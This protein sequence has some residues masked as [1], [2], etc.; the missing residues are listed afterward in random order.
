M[1]LLLAAILLVSPVT[2]PV[3]AQVLPKIQLE[4]YSLANGLRVVL[5]PDRSTQVVT[6][7]VWYDVGSRNEVRGR[8]GF[9]HLFEHMMFQGSANVKKAEYFALIERAGGE[10]NASTAE[11]RTNYYAML[12]SNRLNLGLWLEAD[13]MRALAITAENLDN[14]REAVKEE[15]RLR[16][17]NQ[18]YAGVIYEG[19]YALEDSTRCFSYSHS[20][21]GSM[22]DLNAAKVDD[23][24]SFFDL[25]YAPNNATLVVAGDFEPTETRR[26]VESYFGGIPRG[27]PTPTVTCT[28]SFDRGEIRRPW[29]DSKATLPAAI[30]AY[31]IPSFDD[32]D[33]PALALLATMLGQG[34]SSRLNKTVV[35]TQRLA[36][37]VFA[38]ANLAG[39][40]RG[41]GSLLVAGFANQGIAVNAVESAMADEIARIGREGVSRAE[42]DK[43]KNGYV[44][45]R[46]QQQ[47]ISY[48]LAETIQ[49]AA[50]FLGDPAKVNTEP[51]R[52]LA[53]TV[54]D[55]RR[56]AAK[57]LKPANSAVFLVTPAAA[58]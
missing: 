51:A 34:E 31:R 7:D 28:P 53:V 44:A 23:V 32:P 11:D 52:F 22:A 37:G 18:P 50:M 10:T 16:V 8:T 4:T 21:I 25:Y 26:L 35:R 19:V 43:A 30:L 49:E 9:A 45:N 47:Q 2:S 36:Q 33:Y 27:Q 24:K 20:V 6:V 5:A 29:P 40:R 42:L 46:I 17:D 38:G 58:Q 57:Y 3:E 48:F 56:V 14:Q 39:P 1:R 54:D 41:P 12:P 55:I 15:R 13:R